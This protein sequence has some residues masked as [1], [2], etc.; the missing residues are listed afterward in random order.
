MKRFFRAKPPKETPFL[1]PLSQQSSPPI[2]FS[3][4]LPS[5]LAPIAFTIVGGLALVVV[6]ASLLHTA[7]IEAQAPAQQE[8]AAT[9]AQTASVQPAT[10]PAQ[11]PAAVTEATISDEGATVQAAPDPAATG[12]ILSAIPTGNAL[13]PSVEVAETEAE[14]AALESN[15]RARGHDAS[16]STSG[17]TAI[18]TADNLRNATTTGHV[19]MRSGPSDEA[20]VLAVVPARTRIQAEADC[21][22]CAT[23]YEGRSGYVY[24]SFLSYE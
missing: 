12:S 9:I 11:E 14:I 21:N 5:A 1:S 8:P 4:R 17:Q 10:P 20:E 16:D 6:I 24:K 22:W 18:G 2:S 23:V 7:D 15:Q 3:E 19:N 13:L